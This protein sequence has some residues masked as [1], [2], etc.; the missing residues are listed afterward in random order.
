MV[1]PFPKKTQTFPTYHRKW[2]LK[3][4]PETTRTPKKRP[5]TPQQ[6]HKEN[7]K[8]NYLQLSQNMSKNKVPLRTWNRQCWFLELQVIQ[9]VPKAKKSDPKWPK[10]AHEAPKSIQ[11]CPPS[12]E[13]S[14]HRIE[15]LAFSRATGFKFLFFFAIELTLCT[16]R[17]A[18]NL[19]CL[20]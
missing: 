20:L 12:L 6:K 8:K 17:F 10:T 18:W 15:F 5:G 16:L 14:I 13:N 3:V 1:P 19:A 11:K 9:M 4:T 2:P 7:N